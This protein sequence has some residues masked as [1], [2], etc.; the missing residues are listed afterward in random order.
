MRVD[1]NISDLFF[2][3]DISDAVLKDEKGQFAGYDQWALK[4]EADVFLA[5]LDR[6]GVAAPTSDE[7]LADFYARI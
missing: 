5:C 6:L 3:T 7:L 4:N 2:N 1:Q